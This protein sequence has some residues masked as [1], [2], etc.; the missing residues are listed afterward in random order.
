MQVLVNLQREGG[1]GVVEQQ[2][3]I[4]CGAGDQILRWLAYVACARLSY[5]RG[6]VMGLY[7]PQAVLTADGSVQDVDTVLSEVFDDGDE[8][9]VEYGTGPEAFTARWEGRPATPRF[10][11]GANMGQED[12]SGDLVA[13]L[14]L[15]HYGVDKLLGEQV[16]SNSAIAMEE[17]LASVKTVLAEHAGALQGLFQYY[18][19]RAGKHPKDYDIMNLDD[20]R[21]LMLDARV[22]TERFP[23]SVLDEC[24]IVQAGGGMRKGGKE[25]IKGKLLQLHEFFVACIQVAAAKYQLG[26]ENAGWGYG[27]LHQKLQALVTECLYPHLAPPLTHLLCVFEAAVTPKTMAIMKKGRKLTEQTLNACKLKR[28]ATVEGISRLDLKHLA[29]NLERWGIMPAQ[30][31]ASTLGLMA[32]FAVNE[33]AEVQKFPLRM[34]PLQLDCNAF[35]KLLLALSYH[36]HKRADSGTPFSEAAV[37]EFLSFVYSKAGALA[38]TE[39]ED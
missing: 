22:T 5:Y 31:D 37:G 11:W 28:V 25:V 24:F 19:R 33:N 18:E 9:F 26:L 7:V 21:N 29:V 39:G 17:A 3:P 2:V 32:L 10:L 12:K 34:H 20:F 23:A 8:V 4:Q 30:L 15:R 1:G 16:P 13:S 36:L 14:D 27:E 6:D 35:E 38:I